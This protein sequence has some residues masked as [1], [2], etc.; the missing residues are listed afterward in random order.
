MK[1]ERKSRN[2]AFL[3]GLCG[4]GFCVWLATNS[5]GCNVKSKDSET[6]QTSEGSPSKT[7][8]ELKGEIVID[9]SSTVLPIT[10]AVVEEFMKI[11]P[12]VKID[13]SRSGTGGGF[14]RFGR[15]ETHISNASRPIKESESALAAEN[16][17]EFIEL[18]VAIDGLTVV[19]NK[20][21]DWCDKMTVAQLKKLWEPG[22][23]VT[24]WNELDPSWPD[25]EIVLFGADTDS[26]TFDY[27]TEAINGESKASR[28]DYTPSSD[29]NILVKGVV[30]EKYSLGYFGYAYFH[31]NKDSLKPVAISPTDNPADAVLPTDETVE[32]GSYAPLS[33]PLFIY[34]SKAELKRPE[35]AA[36]LR[37]YLEKGQEYVKEVG[38]VSLNAQITAEMNERLKTALD[39]A[40]K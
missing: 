40:G 5:I 25:H 33:R 6:S 20:E 11:H 29:D 30:G 35:M 9:G 13:V 18:S 26:G 8:S 24:K 32:N 4:I 19:V 34:V 31:E 37:F 23:T 14:K 16:K 17:I 36:F 21:N 28:A 38:Y 2:Q 22:S 3:L 39:E 15:G 27:F 7:T 10:S 1:H 12:D